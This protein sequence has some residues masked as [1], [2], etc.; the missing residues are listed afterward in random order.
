MLTGLIFIPFLGALLRLQITEKHAIILAGGGDGNHDTVPALIHSMSANAILAS[1]DPTQRK[2]RP[3]SFA[4]DSSRSSLG[5]MN[6]TSS[7]STTASSASSNA[8][9]LVHKFASAFASLPP[10]GTLPT[11]PNPTTAAT[12][13]VKTKAKETTIHVFVFSDLIVFTTKDARSSLS[14]SETASI[15]NGGHRRTGSSMSNGFGVGDEH[16]A[17]TFRVEPNGIMTLQRVTDKTG[18]TGKSLILPCL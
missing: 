14:T 6:Y 13:L 9:K 8:D 4:S 3:E 12:R 10:I 16:S 18:T 17:S 15:R 7:D 2:A 1:N 11:S 5:S